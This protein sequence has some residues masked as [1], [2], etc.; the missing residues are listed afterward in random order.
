MRFKNQQR[1]SSIPEVNLV[2]MMDVLMT[3]LTFFIIT[4]MTLT[5][6]RLANVNLP[7]VGAGGDEQKAQEQEPLVVGLNQQREILLDDKAVSETQLA[8]KM[9]AYLAQNPEGSMVL[10]ADR[11]LPYEEVEKVL[12]EMGKTGGSRVSLAIERN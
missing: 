4:S 11:E 5:G 8:E 1:D 12:K 9:Q 10:K 2:P 7:G 3:V 6:Q